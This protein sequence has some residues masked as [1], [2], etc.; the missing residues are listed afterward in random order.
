MGNHHRAVDRQSHKQNALLSLDDLSVRLN[1]L[2][3][4]A[5]TQKKQVNTQDSIFI[6]MIDSDYN[7][8]V[9]IISTPSHQMPLIEN[10]VNMI[11]DALL[12]MDEEAKMAVVS[13]V[14]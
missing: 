12:E 9:R 8:R 5:I 7:E 13:F 6:K 3:L 10:K 14:A 11:D 2:R 1:D 4:L